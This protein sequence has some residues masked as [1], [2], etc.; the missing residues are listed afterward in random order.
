MLRLFSALI[1]SENGM[2]TNICSNTVVENNIF[3]PYIPMAKARGFT[4][5]LVKKGLPHFETAAFYSRVGMTGNQSVMGV[6]T[7][8][9]L[10]SATIS[11]R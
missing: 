10:V 8:S 3:A 7:L 5:H 4:A 11:V 1:I 6:K 9:L 2:Y